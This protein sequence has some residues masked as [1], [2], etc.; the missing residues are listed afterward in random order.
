MNYLGMI[1]GPQLLLLL[2]LPI[3]IITLIALIDVLKSKFKGNDKLIWIVLILFLTI[4]GALL[5][6]I[7][8]KGQ[9]IK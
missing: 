9:K 1:G 5:Y 2:A 7:I 8:G 4:F 6:F 3:L